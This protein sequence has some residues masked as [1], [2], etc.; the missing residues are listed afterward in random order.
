MK[1]RREMI[2]LGILIIALLLGGVI[3]G[4][5][6]MQQANEPAAASKPHSIVMTIGG[7][8]RTTRAFTWQTEGKAGEAGILQLTEGAGPIS[9]WNDS[10]VLTIEAESAEIKLARESG[11]GGR[12]TVH[13]ALASGLRP[14]T[15]YVYRVGNGQESGW[16]EPAE[17][18]TEPAESLAFTFINVSDSQGEKKADF[19]LWAQTLDKAFETFPDARFIVHNGDLTENPDE[20]KGW[21]WLLGTASKWLTRVPLQPVVGNHDEISGNAEVFAS[22]FRLPDNGVDGATPGT[23]YAFDYGFAHFIVLNTESNLKSQTV[24]LKE[25]LRENTKPWTI[26]AMHR[27][28]YGGNQYDKIS[29][30]IEGFDEYSVDLVLQGHNHEYSRSYP[31]R[32]GEIAPD[33]KGTVYVVT[34]TSGP[35]FNVLKKD[36]IY[37]AVHTQPNQQMFAGIAVSER[38]LTYA[39]YAVDGRKLD[40]FTLTR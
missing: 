10:K 31:L 4:W 32:D 36:K 9:S 17:F 40:E 2:W 33:G 38:T 14:G 15:A 23:T 39:A 21:K 29:D 26:V 18:V 16:S 7:D 30:W 19:K 28:A 24:W 11:S 20:E 3:F 22:H 5:Q 35:K 12:Y 25:D 1:G 8:A 13:K 27:P 37:H 6:K 34:N